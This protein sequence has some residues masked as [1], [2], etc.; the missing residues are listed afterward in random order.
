MPFFLDKSNILV[1][2]EKINL[3]PKHITETNDSMEL[4]LYLLKLRERNGWRDHNEPVYNSL[5]DIGDW[6]ERPV[7]LTEKRSLAL[8]GITSF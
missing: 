2:R 1:H 6:L 3:N 5:S 8:E 4:N 7:S